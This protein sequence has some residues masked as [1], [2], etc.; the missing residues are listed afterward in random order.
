MADRKM[1]LLDGRTGMSTPPPS[2]IASYPSTQF[3]AARSQTL[4]RIADLEG[5]LMSARKEREVLEQS[6][7]QLKDSLRL[8][9]TNGGMNG[10][11]Y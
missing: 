3:S 8:G 6:I 1:V 7:T 4:R 2:S 11:A 9:D 5:E 10:Y